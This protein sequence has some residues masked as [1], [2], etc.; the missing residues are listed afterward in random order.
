MLLCKKLLLPSPLV[1]S[2]SL[3]SNDVELALQ[4]LLKCTSKTLLRLL[5]LN[6]KTRKRRIEINPNN[7]LQ[8]F[9]TSVI[10]SRSGFDV[11]TPL[12]VS[13]HGQEAI[14][15]GGVRQSF[16]CQLMHELATSSQ[17]GLFEGD[18]ASG[19]LLPTMN[20]EA[21]MCGHFKMFGKVLIHSLLQE[22]PPFPFF[23]KAVYV[24]ICTKSLEQALPHLSV[25]DLPLAPKEAVKQV[26]SITFSHLH[27]VLK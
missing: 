20:Y 23:P 3:A 10:K 2:L 4:I 11:S 22:G 19:K 16:L 12:E 25:E 7:V 17:L 24:Y 21:L 15:V 6:M 13:F 27:M 26:C 5:A 8:S 1:K 18:L 14:D 9:L